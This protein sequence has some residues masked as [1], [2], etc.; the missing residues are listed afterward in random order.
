[1]ALPNA[2]FDYQDLIDEDAIRI[3]ILHPAANFKTLIQCD[4]I[5]SPRTPDPAYEALS[6]CWGSEEQGFESVVVNG[7]IC[8]VRQGLATAL[9]HLRLTDQPR[10]L[11]A[12]AICINQRCRQEK[13]KQIDRMD[14]TYQKAAKVLVWLGKEEEQSR[15]GMK[16]IEQMGSHFKGQTLKEVHS[17]ELLLPSVE[18]YGPS[19][20]LP[21]IRAI[22][23]REWFSRL[24][25][26]FT[27]CRES[28]AH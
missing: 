5:T 26:C 19:T 1:M 28:L 20:Y 12:D 18:G 7:G 15:L 13:S 3:L 8:N 14:T 21:A 2:G 10:R 4:L 17:Q 16:A 24:W 9:R 6:Y 22:M 27:S 25:V 23:R 11:W